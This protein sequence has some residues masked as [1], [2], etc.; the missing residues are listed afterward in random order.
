MSAK[1]D[2]KNN[3]AN[4][5]KLSDRLRSESSVGLKLLDSPGDNPICSVA[6]DDSIPA[7]VVVW[8]EYATSTQLRF[9]LEYVLHLLESRRLTKILGDDTALRIIHLDDREWILSDWIPRAVQAGL[10]AVASKPSAAHFANV[11]VQSV[12]SAALPPL[13]M[14]V[15]ATI[16]VARAW[17]TCQAP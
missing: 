11:A 12:V 15:F 2:G 6:V 4:L 3:R 14:R 13:E 7:V 16:D 5:S 8:K 1:S 17:L 10:R 9:V